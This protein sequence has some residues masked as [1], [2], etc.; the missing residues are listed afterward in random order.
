MQAPELT[1]L[2]KLKLE[3]TA[4]KYSVLQGQMQS[5]MRDRQ[6]IIE[7]IEQRLPDWQWRE[8][9]G[10]VHRNGSTMEP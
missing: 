3:N 5:L 7:Q 2:E 9:E 4:L 6:I 10:L 1:D 8:G